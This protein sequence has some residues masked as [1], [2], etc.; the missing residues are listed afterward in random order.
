MQFLLVGR[1]SVVGIATR[2]GLGGP[3]IESR[4]SQWPRGLRRESA[5]AHLLGLWGMDVCVVFVVKT[6]VWNVT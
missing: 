2:Y 3:G 4:R 1:D 6:V 5:A